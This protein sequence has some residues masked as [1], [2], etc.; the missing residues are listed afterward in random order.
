M[1]E[2]RLIIYETYEKRAA[3]ARRRAATLSPALVN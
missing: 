1:R 2:F 3:A